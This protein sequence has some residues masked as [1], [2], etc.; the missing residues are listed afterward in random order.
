MPGKQAK[1]LS[2]RHITC[3][4]DFAATTRYPDRNR[5]IVQLSTKA[6]LRAGKIGHQ[7]WEMVV[8]AVGK[9]A[10]VIELRDCAANGHR[11]IQTTQRYID[12]G[13]D[14]Q[15]RLVPLL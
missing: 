9:V 13:S 15:R 2:E 5:L 3:L 7:T 10:A 4:L 12:G 8:D 6:G 11:S 14:A 1:V